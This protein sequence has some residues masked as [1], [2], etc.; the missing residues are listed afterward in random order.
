MN[1]RIDELPNSRGLRDGD[2]LPAS[3]QGGVTTRVRLGDIKTFIRTEVLANAKEHTNEQVATRAEANQSLTATANTDTN[4]S[5]PA[6]STRAIG[7][8]L[9]TIWNKIRSVVNAVNAKAPLAS[10]V[11][12]GTPRAPTP[13][14]SANGTQIATMAALHAVSRGPIDGG[15]DT[16]PLY[17]HHITLQSWADSSWSDGIHFTIIDKNAHHL[18]IQDIYQHLVDNGFTDPNK[19]LMAGGHYNFLSNW[20]DRNY[21]ITGIFGLWNTININTCHGIISL[22]MQSLW[23]NDYVI[24][25]I[26]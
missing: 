1:V 4:V 12:T 9:Q 11:F 20:F 26:R 13:D 19:A 15:S 25:K 3:Q 24:I 2:F 23:V 10:P 6:V 14:L 8:V 5:T 18:D 22:D 7:Q 16:S 17:V 21:L